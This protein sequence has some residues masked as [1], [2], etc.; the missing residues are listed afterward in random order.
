MQLIIEPEL[1]P[2][3]GNLTNCIEKLDI[4]AQQDNINEIEL[5]IAEL[6]IHSVYWSSGLCRDNK[7]DKSVNDYKELFFITRSKEDKLT[8]RLAKALSEG[9][10]ICVLIKYSAGVYGN[11]FTLGRIPR[12][13]F[14]FVQPDKYYPEKNLQA[15]TQGETIESRY[16]F[17]CLDDP[18]VKFPRDI[19]VIVP[20][21]YIVISNGDLV[22]NNPVQPQGRL[23][24]N[25]KED[26]NKV[27][28]IWRQETPISTYLTSVVVGTFSHAE[29]KC[30]ELPL[31]YYWPK[32]VE[33]KNYEPILTFKNTPS[34]MKFFQEYLN[35]KYPYTKYS[36][37]IVDDFDFGG[38]ENAS[39]T[40]LTRNY[41]HDRKASIDYTGD[42]EV[43]CHELAHQWF[44]DL[45][46]CKDWSHT[47]LNEGFATYFEAIYKEHN[48]G[49]DDD[50]FLYYLRQVSSR[51]FNEA[52]NEYKRPLV[53]NAYKH[54]D[55]MFDDH[56]YRKGACVLHMIRHHIG[57]DAFKK[58][59]NVYLD[60]YRNKTAE[61]DDLRQI[62]E[63]VSG[64]NLQS[65][66]EQWVHKPGHPEL[67]IEYSLEEDKNSS[68]KLKI[69]ITQTQEHSNEFTYQFPLEVRIVLS[70]DSNDKLPEIILISNK[71]TEYLYEIP[72]DKSIKWISID[73]EFKILHEIKSLKI[74]EEKHD[75]KLKEM[76]MEQIKNA[77]TVVERMQA[78][79]II[80]DRKY[81]DDYVINELKDLIL[82][83]TFYGVCVIAAN[84]LGLYA[85][86]KDENIRSKVYQSLNEL[87]R[88][89][90]ESKDQNFSTLLPQVR[91]AL[92]S[93][94]GRFERN[95]SLDILNPLLSEQSYF[96]EQQAAI[97]VGR[98]SKNLPLD[99]HEK[100]SMIQLLKDLAN[101][102]TTFQN[103]LARGAIDGLKE[104]SRDE[105]EQIVKDVAD[106]IVAK[107]N[108]GNDYLVRRTAIA[109][110]GKFLR[111]KNKEVNN[112]VF[113]QLMILLKDK[114][115]N[116]QIDACVSL[117]DPDAT[118]LK[119]DAKLLEAIEELTWIAQHDLDGWVRREAEVSLN[120]MRK[121]IKDWLDKPLDLVVS[122][123][124]E[125]R[126]S[127]ERMIQARRSLTDMY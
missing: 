85:S 82:S 77:K 72:K 100:K 12:S 102:T 125:E 49:L 99:S 112:K 83:N 27:E 92:V 79:V 70:N 121:W 71:I 21:D 38:M 40:T 1:L 110:L 19:H 116:L 54:P 61:T 23:D 5:D 62:L 97:A 56:S 126:E 64:K 34:I 90:T 53:T 8:I 103:L 13:G 98:S 55:D 20:Q 69:K 16:W 104:F 58:S 33:S 114:R 42:I 11:D 109:A 46:T 36:Q 80:Q 10:K 63:V 51:Y 18:K 95:D 124:E 66:F 67:E 117:V 123:R 7:W 106:F 9:D 3:E 35:T 93:A 32:D 25:K 107:S 86:S 75:F 14:H 28:W 37:V 47:W 65:F 78:N 26:N 101:T 88:K 111:N 94:L 50:E 43:L 113:D 96:V 29:D 105:D 22:S 120:K 52:T 122:I 74:L 81:T 59:L 44:G 30:G 118:V 15:W 115:F 91:R 57:D 68:R 31:F 17:P 24:N 41:L 76:V 127:E 73:P 108:Y 60:K 87:F 39:C 84:T 119:P 89:N 45:V 48:R 2:T 6:R 4:V